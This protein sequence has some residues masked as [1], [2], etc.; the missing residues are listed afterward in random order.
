MVLA[1]VA[2]VLVKLDLSVPVKCGGNGVQKPGL[3]PKRLICE[4]RRVSGQRPV[5]YGSHEC[6]LAIAFARKAHGRV[7]H[8]D[9]EQSAMQGVEQLAS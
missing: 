3:S 5:P 7:S 4:P 9:R 1:I 6:Y 8:W 2:A